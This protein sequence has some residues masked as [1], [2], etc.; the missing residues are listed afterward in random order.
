M[1][2]NIGLGIFVWD[3][4]FKECTSL[5]KVIFLFSIVFVAVMN[6]ALRFNV[7][8]RQSF[9]KYGRHTYQTENAVRVHIGHLH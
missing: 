2:F 3:W 6:R 9:K 4:A 8:T 5:I 1:P 7:M